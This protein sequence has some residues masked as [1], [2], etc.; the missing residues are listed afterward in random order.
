MTKEVLAVVPA[1]GGSKGVPGKNIKKLGGKS[2]IGWTIEAGLKSKGITRLIVSTD[3]DDIAQEAKKCGA[4]I[5]FIRPS[6]FAQ[7]KSPTIDVIRHAL[8]ALEKEEGYKPDAVLIL[9]PTT[10]F[11]TADDIDSAIET[12]FAHNADCVVS[13][14]KVPGH[15]HP[16]W[17]IV[18]QDEVLMLY[19]GK[20]IK[21]II[22]RRQDL[23]DTF[24]RN[25]EIYVIKPSVVIEQ[26]S[27]Y[28]DKIYP[29]YTEGKINIDTLD[30]FA[31]A[32]RLIKEERANA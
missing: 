20:P 8:E 19:N 12:F 28:G 22:K 23:G 13:L 6:E 25:G 18:E 4:E 14:S 24:Y 30:D 27:L 1:R 7:D 15:F 10:P 5:P 2:L 29:V 11:R 3:Y 31:Q 9:Q 16:D 21:E 17:Q 26:N 32:E